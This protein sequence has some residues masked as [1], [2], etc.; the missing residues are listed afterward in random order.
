MYAD[1]EKKSK[2]WKSRRKLLFL[3]RIE[4][5]EKEDETE[6]EGRRTER[7]IKK[8]GETPPAT[9]ANDK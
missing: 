2:E 7:K 6:R 5:K 3:G 8:E 9:R 1:I 4:G